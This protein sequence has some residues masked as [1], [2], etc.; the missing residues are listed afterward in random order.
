MVTTAVAVAVWGGGTGGVD[1]HEGNHQDGQKGDEHDE[2]LG[3]DVHC[4]IPRPLGFGVV[5]EGAVLPRNASERGDGG[6][7]YGVSPP[8]PTLPWIVPDGARVTVL[9]PRRASGV[10]EPGRQPS[11]HPRSD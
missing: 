11:V 7:G 6:S 4:L 8:W 2:D 9:Y 10:N 3:N 1:R 5:F